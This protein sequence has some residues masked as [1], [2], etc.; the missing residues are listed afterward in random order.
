[1]AMIQL[2]EVNMRQVGTIKIIILIK[3]QTPFSR[4]Q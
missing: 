4:A 3:K 2:T 1:M